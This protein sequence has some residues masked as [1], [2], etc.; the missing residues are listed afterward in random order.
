MRAGISPR[1][2]GEGPGVRAGRIIISAAEHQSVIEPAEHL[3]EHGWRLDTLGLTPAGVV[4]VDQLPPL[5]GDCPNFRGHRGEA[6]VGEN[7]TVPLDAASLVSV[8]LG[9][10]ET[11]VLQPLAELAADLQSGR[12]P[13]AHRRRA[14]FVG[15]LPVSFRG[16]DVAAMSISAHKFARLPGIGAAACDGVPLMPLTFRGHQQEDFAPAPSRSRW[17]SA[18]PR[19]WNSG[20]EQDEHARRLT[21]LRDRFE[22]GLRA[23]LPNI[24]V[25]GGQTFVSPVGQTFLSAESLGRQLHCRPGDGHRNCHPNI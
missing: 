5:L 10:H 16:L 19:L 1:P 15:K 4:R 14:S 20:G 22:Q 2:L 21:A 13:A 9:N 17:S 7:G 11:G 25:H 6:V 8:Q 24:V 3:L 23:A 12:R 18:W